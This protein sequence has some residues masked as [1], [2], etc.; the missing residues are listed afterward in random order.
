MTRTN[1]F[2]KV[3]VE[4]GKEEKPERLGEEICR[5]LRKL[6]GVRDAELTNFTKAEE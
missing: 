5:T 3:E 2:F 6:Y 4:H 1:L